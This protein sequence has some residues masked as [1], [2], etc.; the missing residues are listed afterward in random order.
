VTASQPGLARD[1]KHVFTEELRAQTQPRGGL[2]GRLRECS[3]E[4]AVVVDAP[5]AQVLPHVWNIK[6]VEYC[7]R[8]ADDVQ[9]SAEQSWTGRYVIR[10]RIFG[11]VPWQGPFRY[12]LHER[13]FHSEDAAPRRGGL[14]V[15]GGFTAQPDGER[16]RIWHYER[17]LLPWPVA[18]LKPLVTA[19]VRWTQRREMRDFAALIERNQT[20]AAGE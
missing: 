6:N 19:Y 3:A 12:V 1:G 10:G 4:R 5:V 15:N 14:H 20:P 7:E 18:P 2:T 17:Y 8:K 9:V 16:T 11:V 13:G